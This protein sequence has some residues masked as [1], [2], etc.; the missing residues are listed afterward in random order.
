MNTKIIVDERGSGK[1]TKAIKES[2]RTGKYI[3][4]PNIHMARMI[5]DSARKMDIQIPF[6]VAVEE[7]N[8]SRFRGSSISRDGLI[9]DEALMTLEAILGVP[10]HM[11][12]MSER[13]E[14]D[15][16]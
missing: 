2:A 10:I 7:L 6:P 5:Y 16:Q 3:L 12:T 15:V 14:E 9:I 8:D 4:A 1:T 13:R 11:I